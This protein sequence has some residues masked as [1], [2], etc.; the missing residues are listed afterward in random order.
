MTTKLIPIR[1]KRNGVSAMLPEAYLKHP[2]W[3]D[4]FEAVR[5]TKPVV[6]VT[7]LD[8]SHLTSKH[9]DEDDFGDYPE[10]FDTTIESKEGSE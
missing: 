5:N 9:E 7:P 2:Q 1:D 10:D 3:R 4:H 8:I 6:N